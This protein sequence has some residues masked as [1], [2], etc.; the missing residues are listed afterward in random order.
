MILGLDAGSRTVPE[1]EHLLHD[2]VEALGLPAGTIGC[3]H[4]VRTATGLP[5]VA[6]SVSLTAAG[7][8]GVDLSAVPETMGVALGERR[9]GPEAL[10]EGAALAAAEHAGRSGGRL[11]V[12]PGHDELTGTLSVAEL[13]E[14]SAIDR[15]AVLAQT[16]EPASG[17]P[18]AT[19]DFVRPQWRDGRAVLLTM[20]AMGG[21]LMPAEVPNPTPCCADHA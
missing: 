18:V 13:L 6:L 4:F 9:S 7:D 12:Y 20:P 15:V 10:A 14:R 17:T 3:T 2:M 8:A 5:H 21:R 19:Q 11:V 1:A 16:E